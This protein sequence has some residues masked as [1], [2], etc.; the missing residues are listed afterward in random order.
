MKTQ[1]HYLIF[2]PCDLYRLM[3]LLLMPLVIAGCQW[4]TISSS[5][6]EMKYGVDPDQVRDVTMVNFLSDEGAVELG[7]RIAKKLDAR[8][9]TLYRLRFSHHTGSFVAVDAATQKPA[10]YYIAKKRI[11]LMGPDATVNE[12][13]KPFAL[14]EVPLNAISAILAKA[15]ARTKL[16]DPWITGINFQCGSKGARRLEMHVSFKKDNKNDYVKVAIETGG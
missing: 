10:L 15:R 9:V 14:S 8:Q 16:D 11:G 6:F 1:N 13:D 4:G 5:E 3:L 2:R 12:D 7:N